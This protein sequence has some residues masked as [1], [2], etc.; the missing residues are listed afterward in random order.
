MLH[1]DY[2]EFIRP[3]LLILIPVMYLLG[4]AIKKTALRDKLIPLVL[5][6][7]A[8]LLSG[9]YL[10][11]VSDISGGRNI[12]MAVFTAITQGILIAGASVYANQIW[13][14]LTQN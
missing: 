2:T 12:A 10:F 13:K 5:G 14:Q 8:I 3:E 11:A 4:A 9:I 6:A 7:A 1:K